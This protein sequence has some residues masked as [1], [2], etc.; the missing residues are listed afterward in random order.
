MPNEPDFSTPQGWGQAGQRMVM[1]PMTLGGMG[2]LSGQGFQGMMAGMN[3]GQAMQKNQHELV[4]QQ[5]RDAYMQGLNPNDPRYKGLNPALLDLS[6]GTN[7]PGLLG[8][9]LVGKGDQD[10]QIQMLQRQGAIQHGLKR[11][12][13]DYAK[14]LELS[15]I[16]AKA[17]LIKKLSGEGGL[18]SGGGAPQALQTPGV[19]VWSPTGGL[20]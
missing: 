13:M 19:R 16:E 6:K 1:N 11:Q 10:F 3:G 18:L 4:Q 9:A 5:A 12:D 20:Q 15:Q 8:K 14:Q 17:A 7:D 2:L